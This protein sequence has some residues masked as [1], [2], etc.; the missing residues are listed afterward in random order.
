MSEYEQVWDWEKNEIDPIKT[1]WQLACC[2]CGLVHRVY[3]KINGK[4]LIVKYVVDKKETEKLRRS[5]K[6]KKR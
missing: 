5:K 6:Q 1:I 2:D 3:Y 4:K